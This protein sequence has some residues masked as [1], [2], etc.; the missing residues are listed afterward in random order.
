MAGIDMP[1]SILGK[2]IV[3]LPL[4]EYEELKQSTNYF[5]E[6]LDNKEKQLDAAK[7]EVESLRHDWE[8]HNELITQ[9]FQAFQ[10]I[11]FSAKEQL[12]GS[13]SAPY[14]ADLAVKIVKA[15]DENLGGAEC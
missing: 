6:L 14:V 11:K 4:K 7:A 12:S 1:V 10:A 3:V 5:R 8:S 2:G 15:C 13:V 9:H